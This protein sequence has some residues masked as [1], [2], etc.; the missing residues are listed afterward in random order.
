ML[1]L[2]LAFANNSAAGCLWLSS[3]H[4]GGTAVSSA[5]VVAAAARMRSTLSLSW[6]YPSVWRYLLAIATVACCVALP[7]G[8]Y[9][10]LLSC[11]NMGMVCTVYCQYFTRIISYFEFELYFS[12]IVLRCPG[13]VHHVRHQSCPCLRRHDGFTKSYFEEIVRKDFKIRTARELTIFGF[14]KVI[15]LLSLTHS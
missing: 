7:S 10:C 9:C 14:E 1:L 4:S 11:T 6:L 15:S 8:A 3:G 2:L 12:A 5:A 13:V